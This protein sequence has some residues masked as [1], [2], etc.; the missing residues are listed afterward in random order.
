MANVRIAVPGDG[1]QLGQVM[2]MV[3]ETGDC[4]ETRRIEARME[5]ARD[6]M[7]PQKCLFQMIGETTG[8]E[9]GVTLE[10]SEDASTCWSQ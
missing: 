9:R 2:V 5:V 1:G 10:A 3:V 6:E 8:Q 7:P 4:P